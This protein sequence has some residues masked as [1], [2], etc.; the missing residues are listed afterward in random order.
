MIGFEG[1]SLQVSTTENPWENSAKIFRKIFERN[2]FENPFKYFRNASGSFWKHSGSIL[3]KEFREKNHW[4]HFR[5][6]SLGFWGKICKRFRKNIRKESLEWDPEGN[7][8][9][10]SENITE[11]IS[12]KICVR[13]SEGIFVQNNPKDFNRK[14]RKNYERHLWKKFLNE[15]RE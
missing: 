12:G 2:F 1:K 5:K 9:R 7:P 10:A 6:E 8:R 13:V 4:I 11:R 3:W 14:L 15:F